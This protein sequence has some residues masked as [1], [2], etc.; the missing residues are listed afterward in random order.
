[1]RVERAHIKYDSTRLILGPIQNSQHHHTQAYTHCVCVSLQHGFSTTSFKFR[2][3]RLLVSY[4]R[5]VV[6]CD[7]DIWQILL[8]KTGNF[9]THSLKGDGVTAAC[10]T[11]KTVSFDDSLAA[12]YGTAV[13][14]NCLYYRQVKS[15]NYTRDSNEKSYTVSMYNKGI[16]QFYLPPT[17]GP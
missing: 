16:T 2:T 10:G 11:A 8:V 15:L 6:A 5:L 4:Y 14:I 3:L 13:I 7:T 17:H 12:S 1:M 9:I